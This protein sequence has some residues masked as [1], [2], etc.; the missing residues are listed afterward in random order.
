MKTFLALGALAALCQSA[1]CLEDGIYMIGSAT[2]PS[3]QVLG[4]TDDIGFLAFGPKNG[5]PGQSWIFNS[6][7]GNNEREFLIQNYLG[8]YINCGVDEGSLCSAGDE[9]E[10]YTAELVSDNSYQLVAKNSGYFMRAQGLLLQL[11]AW[12]QTPNENFVLTAI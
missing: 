7:S 5:H 4:E 9:E 1:F 12:D 8:S 2:L 6:S 10:F 11:A 3:S